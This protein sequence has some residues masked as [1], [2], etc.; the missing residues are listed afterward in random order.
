MVQVVYK[1]LFHQLDASYCIVG[2]EYVTKNFS[3]IPLADLLII[4]FSNNFI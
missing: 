2:E 1:I 3:E 4:S